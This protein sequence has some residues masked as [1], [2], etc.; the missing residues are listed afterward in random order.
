MEVCTIKVRSPE[1]KKKNKSDTKEAVRRRLNRLRENPDFK[2]L[3]AEEL[4]N[5]RRPAVVV[6]ANSAMD[7]W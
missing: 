5:W 1:K 4:E 7:I 6:S 2:V 3:L